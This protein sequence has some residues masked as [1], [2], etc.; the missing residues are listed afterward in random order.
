M[1]KRIRAVSINMIETLPIKNI[2]ISLQ[3]KINVGSVL[4]DSRIYCA[5]CT[6][7]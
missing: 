3:K 5:H 7:T 1:T 2:F 4:Y 6:A